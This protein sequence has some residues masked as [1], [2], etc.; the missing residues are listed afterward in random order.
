MKTK[1][2]LSIEK[3]VV[4]EAKEYAAFKKS[5][6][7]RIVENAL[8]QHTIQA[9]PAFGDRWRGRFIPAG[10]RDARYSHLMERHA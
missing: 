8:E 2:T 1:L 4:D 10:K 6:L 5:S 3:A 7:S 9:R